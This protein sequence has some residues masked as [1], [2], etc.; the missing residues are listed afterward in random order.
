MSKSIAE[1]TMLDNLVPQLEA[2]GYEVYLQPPRSL[3]PS[4][5]RDYIPDLVAFGTPKNIAVEIKRP[6]TGTDKN[7]AGISAMFE[8]QE[9]WDLKIILM[10][11]TSETKPLKPQSSKQIQEIIAEA[12]TL[13]RNG[14][15]RPALLIGW[16][17]FE[18]IARILAER[19]FAKP[20]TP[21]RLINVLAEEGFLTPSEFD[22]LKI[23][24]EKR[25]RLVH[26]EIDTSVN[27]DEIKSFIK[28]IEMLNALVMD[29]SH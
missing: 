15:H 21:A 2:E 18:A 1:A 7:L 17:I 10:S 25:N 23:L 6:G 12:R 28:I 11:P 29:A 26:G 20:Q 4:F 22:E 16:A 3:L 14:H 24:A 5:M 27:E 8:G 13:S 19:R 9:D